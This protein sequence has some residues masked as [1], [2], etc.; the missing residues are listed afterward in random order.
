VKAK[1][2]KIGERYVFRGRWSPRYSGRLVS[3]GHAMTEKQHSWS[4]PYVTD[5]NGHRF[6]DLKGLERWDASGSVPVSII[7][8]S[9]DVQATEADHE[10]LEAENRVIPNAIQ[11]R[12]AAHAATVALVGLALGMEDFGRVVRPYGDGIM[13]EAAAVD[14]LL[15]SLGIE[16][17]TP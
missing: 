1:D 6:E 12:T 5:K 9:R 13:V 7:V 17:V 8:R 16:K 3:V 10:R 15:A 2:L 14:A 11:A 4:A